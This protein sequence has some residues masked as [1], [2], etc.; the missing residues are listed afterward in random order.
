MTMMM[1]Q[2]MMESSQKTQEQQIQGQQAEVK[3][4]AQAEVDTQLYLGR[5]R[6]T[7]EDS[8]DADM[9]DRDAEIED[10]SNVEVDVENDETLC[11]VDLTR[12]QERL[13]FDTSGDFK[14][15]SSHK[16]D[17]PM[18]NVNG[19][20][21]VCSDVSRS[22]SPRD[23]DDSPSVVSHQNRRLAFSVENILDPN[24]FTGRQAGFGDGVCCW[25]PHQESVGSS[26]FEG[27][28]IGKERAISV[29]Y[30]RVPQSV[31]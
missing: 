26:D 19:A 4:R 10:E 24:K 27:S 30:R 18:D 5:R 12:R 11:P 20:E 23:G 16:D 14:G 7:S 28:E 15:Y 29:Q 31:V 8:R 1:M 25:K 9:C 13:A 2:R 3:K 6:R 21:S 22:E 17:I